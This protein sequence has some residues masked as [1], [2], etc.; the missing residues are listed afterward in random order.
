MDVGRGRQVVPGRRQESLEIPPGLVAANDLVDQVADQRLGHRPAERGHRLAGGLVNGSGLVAGEMGDL[1]QRG[2]MG[3]GDALG[4]GVGREQSEHPAGGDVPG[5]GGQLGEGAGQEIMESVGGPGGLLDLALQAAGDLAQQGHGSLGLGRGGGPLDQREAGHGPALGVV[6]GALGGVRLVV[7]LVALGLAD[8][9]GHGPVE[10]AEELLEVVGV[11]AG[12]VDTDME[13]DQRMLSAQLLEA[14]AQGLVAGAVLGDGERLG[15]GLEIGPEERDAVAVSGGVDADA[16]AVE[17]GGGRHGSHPR[18]QEWVEY[19]ECRRDERGTPP[20]ILGEAI[21]VMSGRAARCTNAL[22]PSR[23][24]QSPT[25]GQGLRRLIAL[26]TTPEPVSQTGPNRSY[27]AAPA[28]DR[29]G[30]AYVLGAA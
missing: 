17:G 22:N 18:R 9:E 23:R 2:E 11:L 28:A 8:G 30:P 20:G 19:D 10:V 21:L 16:D 12:G 29:S 13:V 4:G 7:V 25:R 26:P 24:E 14:V 1:L 6:G 27:K 3:R 15:G 5:E